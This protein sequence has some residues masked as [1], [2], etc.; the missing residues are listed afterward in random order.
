MALPATQLL[1]KVDACKSHEL[2]CTPPT[3]QLLSPTLRKALRTRQSKR[4][5]S[6]LL[7]RSHGLRGSMC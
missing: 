5:T 4:C 7:L 6:M 2:L 1:A 3:P